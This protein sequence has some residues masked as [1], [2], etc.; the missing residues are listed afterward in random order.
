MSE[1]PQKPSADIIHLVSNNL[2]GGGGGGTHDGMEHR[3]SSLEND[4]RAMRKDMTDIKV[5][6]AE[7]N[8]KLDSKIDYKWLAVY[9]L[10]IIA[11]ILRSE[12][13]SMFTNS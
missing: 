7:V 2:K 5:T 9:V 11:V 6:L 12:I 13:A 3:V 10:G 1:F 4:L 8:A